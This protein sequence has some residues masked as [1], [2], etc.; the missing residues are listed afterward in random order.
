VGKSTCA[1]A[2]ALVLAESTSVTLLGTDPAGSIEDVLGSAL[3]DGEARPEERLMVRQVRAAEEFA[4]LTERYRESVERAF[5]ALGLE[6]SAALDRR[7]LESLL[8]LA[9]PGLDEAFAVAALLDDVGGL[10]EGRRVVVDT[11]PT[12]HFLRLLAM[13]ELALAWTHQLLRLLLKY[14][15]ALGLDAFAERLL[16]FAKQLRELKLTLSDPERSAAIVVTQPGPLVAAESRRLF[17]RVRGADLRVGAVIANRG[18][19]S[20]SGLDVPPDTRL[21]AAPSLEQSPVG[22]AALRAFARSWSL[23]A[24]RLARPS[25]STGS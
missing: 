22:P 18:D 12:G 16:D 4:S 9:P 6:R 7:V 23:G 25:T 11:A 3:E 8:G 10:G 21:L 24:A 15:N 1:A 17:A 13:P 5:E 14:R 19:A 2:A 20:A